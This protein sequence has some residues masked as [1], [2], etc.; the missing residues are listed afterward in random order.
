MPNSF[1][2]PYGITLR[3]DGVLDAVPVAEIKFK[4]KD[5]DWLSF[6]LVVDS[7]ATISAFPKSDAETF[8][9]NLSKTKQ[10]F[11]SG[12][13]GEKIKGWQCEISA[14][15]NQKEIILPVAFLNIE[16]APRVL[17][18]NGIFD[19]YILMFQEKRRR[20]VFI[21]EDS[22]NVKKIEKIIIGI[23]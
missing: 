9:I 2:C 16:T 4:D 1:I 13:G 21:G 14:R 23:K 3:E 8:G 19:K 7:G 10:I 6:F 11:I 22:Q 5:G 12:I 15:L 17:G 20:T 18:R